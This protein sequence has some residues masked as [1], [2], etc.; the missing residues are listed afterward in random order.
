VH[1]HSL[2]RAKALKG[3]AGLDRADFQADKK[4]I[5]GID[6]HKTT[7]HRKN[8][9]SGPGETCGPFRTVCL[10]GEKA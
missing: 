6:R 1:G 7:F 4:E 8:D 2:A 10:G 5:G 9:F 3:R